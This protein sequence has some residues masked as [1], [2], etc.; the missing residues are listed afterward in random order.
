MIKVEEALERILSAVSVLEEEESPL[1]EAVGRVLSRDIHSAID[2]PPAD[3][4]AMDG[5]AVQAASTRGASPAS[6]R[7]LRVT[8]QIAAGGRPGGPVGPGEAV[9][10][11]TGAPIPPGA[12]AVVQFEDTDE[13]VRRRAQDIS[14]SHIGILREASAG[15]NIRRAG[16]DIPRGALVLPRG[17]VVNPPQVGVLASLGMVRAPVIR[18]PV[19]AIIGTGDELTP[20][21][22]PLPPGRIYDSNTYA[23]AAQVKR[24]GAIP[25]I[26]GIARDVEADLRDKVRQAAEADL[27]LTSGG[28]SQGDYDMVKGVLAQE[29]E[30]NFWTV[31][32]KPGKPLAFGHFRRGQ[33][34]VPHLGLPGNPVSSMITFAVFGRPA[35]LK[36]MGKGT[37]PLPTVEAVMEEEVTNRDGRRYYARVSLSRRSGQY[38]ARLSGPQGSGILSS[39]AQAD[40][41]AIIPE[42]TTRVRAG[43]RVQVMLLE[44]SQEKPSLSQ[45]RG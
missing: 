27:V 16:E 34:R 44:W 30:M 26:M 2:V 22:E 4:S 36:M 6:P 17:T 25:R 45:E 15:L 14:L 7:V 12:D 33:R 8:G 23:L 39:M 18:R 24:L 11:M 32:M 42:D 29:G 20:L 5:F 35:V 19:V 38:H 43:D 21:G 28:V 31:S 3:N 9:R 40:G 1:L 10:I 37:A 41:L 13:E